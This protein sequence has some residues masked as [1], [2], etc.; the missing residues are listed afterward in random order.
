MNASYHR[1]GGLRLRKVSTTF[2]SVIS[3]LRTT[4]G[5]LLSQRLGWVFQDAD[6]LHTPEAIAKM[7]SGIPLDDQDRAPWL[8]S[9]SVL[10]KALVPAEVIQ[11]IA[12]MD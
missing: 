11:H 12:Q 7:K 2:S 10:L 1:D 6:E 4:T 9:L 8:H 3:I 5:V